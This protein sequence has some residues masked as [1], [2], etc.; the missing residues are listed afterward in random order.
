MCNCARS[1]SSDA[2]GRPCSSKLHLCSIAF[3]SC[4]CL[5]PAACFACELTWRQVHVSVP[6]NPS[7]EDVN[8]AFDEFCGNPVPVFEQGCKDMAV[9]R[10]KMVED[11]IAGKSFND[12]CSNAQ[13]CWSGLMMSGM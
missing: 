1:F 12:I 7:A 9:Q 2:Y 10:W 4:P 3:V 8:A 13:V 6:L 5:L 11:Y